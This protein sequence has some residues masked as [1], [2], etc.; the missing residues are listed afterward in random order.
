MAKNRTMQAKNAKVKKY[1]AI[2]RKERQTVQIIV[3][4]MGHTECYGFYDLENYIGGHYNDKY[5]YVVGNRNG[6]YNMKSVVKYNIGDKIVL[7]GKT[8]YV[9]VVIS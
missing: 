4:G 8:S 9:K 3:D 2:A 1:D 7:K 6:L 5:E